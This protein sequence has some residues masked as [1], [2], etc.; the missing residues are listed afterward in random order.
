MLY[1]FFGDTVFGKSAAKKQ[2]PDFST[3]TME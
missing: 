1:H 3:G 2:L